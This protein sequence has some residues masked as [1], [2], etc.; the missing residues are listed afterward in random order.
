MPCPDPSGLMIEEY[1]D[2]GFTITAEIWAHG[3]RRNRMARMKAVARNIRHGG[4]RCIGCDRLVPLYKRVDARFCLGKCR[5]LTARARR[6]GRA[7]P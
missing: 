3:N 2:G 4:W 5:K 1:K 6:A 7:E